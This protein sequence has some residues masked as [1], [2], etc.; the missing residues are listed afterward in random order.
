MTASH[1]PRARG[2]GDPQLLGLGAFEW[3]LQLQSD[4][5][6]RTV[7]PRQGGRKG[8]KSLSH[9]QKIFN[10]SQRSV[11]SNSGLRVKRV[12][13]S[14]DWREPSDPMP[15]PGPQTE[16]QKNLSLSRGLGERRERAEPREV[17]H[18]ENVPHC[19]GHRITPVSVPAPNVS[20]EFCCV[21]VLAW[22]KHNTP[23]PSPTLQ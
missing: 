17:R 11:A 19:W 3:E 2:T 21:Y 9:C 14:L 18:M 12:C 15:L 22:D 10:V 8:K 7:F 23:D 5:L 1:R 16:M 6:F 20:R 4:S 13:I